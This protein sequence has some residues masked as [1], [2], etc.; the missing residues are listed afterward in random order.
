MLVS[1]TSIYGR[2]WW[3]ERLIPQIHLPRGNPT[4]GWMDLRNQSFF[5]SDM[6]INRCTWDT[7]YCR[8]QGA[9]WSIL[10]LMGQKLFLG[11]WHNSYFSPTLW[12]KKS[13]KDQENQNYTLEW[14]KV[15]NDMMSDTTNGSSNWELITS[16]T[17]PCRKMKQNNDKGHTYNAQFRCLIELLWVHILLPAY[18][19][20]AGTR[21]PI[22]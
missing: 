9:H 22:Y 6:T 5:P 7:S 13:W 11:V 1:G 19:Y 18:Q 8:N 10:S 12:Q 17:D 3:K 2:V 20:P 16:S 15:G 14:I 21:V 4:S